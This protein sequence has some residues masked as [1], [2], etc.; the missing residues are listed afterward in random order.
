MAIFAQL[1]LLLDANVFIQAYQQYYPFDICPGFWDCL[2][3]LSEQGR[4]TSID[5]VQMELQDHED[6]L[7]RWA[8]SAPSLFAPT[9]EAPVVEAY[10]EVI[11]WVNAN[12][13]FKPGTKGDFARK[14][15]G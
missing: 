15:D 13:Q 2:V 14:A 4:L 1:L 6:D 10:Q 11:R 9:D 5:R 12:A 7:K 3:A 8:N